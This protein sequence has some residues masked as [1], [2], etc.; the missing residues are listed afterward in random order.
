MLLITLYEQLCREPGEEIDELPYKRP[1]RRTAVGSLHPT[2]Q[3]AQTS[4]STADS[5]SL[6]KNCPH[7]TTEE[8]RIGIPLSGHTSSKSNT[9]KVYGHF[10]A[11]STRNLLA[12]R[13]IIDSFNVGDL[14]GIQG[15]IEHTVTSDCNVYIFPLNQHLRGRNALMDLWESMLEAFPD[16]VFRASDTTINDKGEVI[17]RFIFTGAKQFHIRLGNNPN[18]VCGKEFG[19][20]VPIENS[21]KHYDGNKYSDSSSGNVED[22]SGRSSRA[23][24]KSTTS[25]EISTVITDAYHGNS[26]STHDMNTRGVGDISKVHKDMPLLNSR[27]SSMLFKANVATIGVDYSIPLIRSADLLLDDALDEIYEGCMIMHTNEQYQIDR[28]DYHWKKQS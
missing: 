20:I 18:F 15:I 23:A 16:G 3:K 10:S 21:S 4:R 2:R 13:R 24:S 14:A 22:G 5:T 12:S 25:N 9:K 6:S 7:D 1:S 26:S 11:S 19:E 8:S 17:T 27:A 28:L